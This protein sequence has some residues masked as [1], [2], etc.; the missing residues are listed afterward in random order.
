[1]DFLS[2]IFDAGIRTDTYS[3]YVLNNSKYKDIKDLNDKIIGISDKEEV[4]TNKAIDKVSNKIEFNMAEYDNVS[5]NA[6]ALIDKDIDAILALESNID[7]LKDDSDKYDNLKA[8]YKE[9]GS[10]LAIMEQT[11]PGDTDLKLARD[12]LNVVNK[13]VRKNRRETPIML[14]IIIGGSVLFFASLYFFPGWAS[15]FKQVFFLE[16]IRTWI[17]SIF[18]LFT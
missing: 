9:A 14:L 3:I 13:Q 18:A 12:K 16:Y 8:I 17:L 6:D 1:M 10:L 7:I 2:N 5:E 4:S 15:F 11:Y